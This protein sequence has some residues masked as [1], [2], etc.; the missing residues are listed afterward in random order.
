MRISKY[1]VS[2]V[3]FALILCAGAFAEENNSGS[4]NLEQPAKVG[5]TLLQPGHYKAEWT[6]PNDAVKI[7]ILQ[8]GKTVATVDGHVKELPT[9]SPYS[10]VSMK[11]QPDNSQA[12]NEIDFNNRSEALVIGGV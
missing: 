11:T 4:F 8:H 1:L 2:L 5:S 10:A 3:G 12:V 7:N 9:K 6:G